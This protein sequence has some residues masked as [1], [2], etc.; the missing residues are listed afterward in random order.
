[1]VHL[2][3]PHSPHQQHVPVKGFEKSIKFA[4]KATL[5]NNKKPPQVQQD[6]F[7]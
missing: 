7:S 1:M 2:P 6:T 4:T 3:F 5:K